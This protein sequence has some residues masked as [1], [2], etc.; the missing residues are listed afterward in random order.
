MSPPRKKALRKVPRTRDPELS[1]RRILDAAI[2]LI[3]EGGP[4]RITHRS[5]A[6]RAGVSLGTT[7]YHFAS[8]EELIRAAFHHYLVGARAMLSGIEGTTQGTKVADVVEMVVAT[9]LLGI[10][11]R[12]RVRTEFE[13][14]FY[15]AGDAVVARE[16]LAYERVVESELAL[17]LERLD[18]RRPSEAARTVVD[19]VRGF[20]LERFA[21]PDAD[22][23]ALGRR[24]R[25]VIAGLVKQGGTE[26]GRTTTRRRGRTTR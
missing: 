12:A 3:G 14:I 17:I 7:T 6:G 25:N 16:F 2:E 15:S 10:R 4:E 19:M 11:E 13:L 1:R 23:D 8:R 22:P 20:E 26:A 9:A 24:V 21:R 18:V 5:V